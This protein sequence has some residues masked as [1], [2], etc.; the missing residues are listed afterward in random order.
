MDIEF[1]A[2]DSLGTRSM[3]TVI[4][5]KHVQ[6][7]IDPSAALGPRRYGL[8]P[9]P[10]EYEK[11][12]EHKEVIVESS[13]ESDLIIVTHYHYDH[14]PRPSEGVAWLV[15]KKLLIKDPNHM[16]NF[17][18][19][20]RARNFLEMLSKFDVRV[21]AVDGGEINVG[22]TKIKFS[23]PVQHGNSSKLGYVLEVLVEDS[24]EKILF[25]SDVE[26]PVDEEQVRF[27]LSN[28]P[29]I[30][31]CDGPMTYMLG[32]KYGWED[33][34]KALKNLK[35]IIVKT[36]LSTLILDHHLV[37]DKDWRMKIREF[38]EEVCGDVEIHTAASYM[39][40]PEN[41][42]ESMRDVLWREQPQKP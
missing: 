20:M 32:D 12:K 13:K 23:R 19:R 10:L 42:L 40:L 36:E 6:I 3:A 4:K 15:G 5:T 38:L 26:G 35:R 27:I 8:P 9:H 11:L 7:M 34:E 39:G 24:G 14:I 25:T 21:E 31:I 30:L 33:L 18:Q 2:F 37:R 17:S 22:G 28:K 1:V 41:P 16:I 29:D